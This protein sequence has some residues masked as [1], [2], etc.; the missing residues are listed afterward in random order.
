VFFEVDCASDSSIS[1]YATGRTPVKIALPFA[2]GKVYMGSRANFCEVLKR[3]N[4]S[5]S[6]WQKLA[7]V[8]A[9]FMAGGLLAQTPTAV[10]VLTWRY[11]LT[12]AGDNTQETL[13]TPTNVSSGAFGKLFSL[14]VDDHVYAQPL[15]VPNLTMSDGKVH[16]VLFVATE[17]D[18]IY[19]FD[20]DAKGS[21]IWKV[22]LLTAAYGAGAGATPVPQADV[23]PSEDIG[24]NIGITGTPAINPATD[25]MYVVA[26][27]KE[28]GQ[29][30]SR[31]HAI[32]IITGAE[33]SGS[34]VNI[35]ASVAGTGDGSSGGQVPFLPLWT[36]QRPA[37]DYY[38]GYV[39]IAYSSHGDVSP[40]HGW[41]FAYNASTLQQTAVLCLTPEDRGASV[42]GSGAGMPIDTSIPGGRMFVVT[43]NGDRNTPFKSNSDYGESVLAFNIAN[44][45]LTPTDEWSAFNYETLNDNDWDQGSGGLLMLPDQPGTYLHLIIT[46]GK[47]GRV[48]VLNRDSLG[49]IATGASSNTNAVQD[50]TVSGIPAG[51]GFW[52]T[53]AYW[54]GN[55]Y[56]WAGGDDGGTPNV[57]MQFKLNDGVLSTTPSSQTTFTSAFPGPTFSVS[58]NGTQD[59]I[60]WAVKADQFSSYGP[61]VLYAFDANDLSTILYE[62]DK[63]SSDTAGLA[64]KFSVPVVTNGKVYFAADGEVDV[65]GLTNA[66]HAAAAPVITPSGGT[67]TSSQSVTMSSATSA[68]SIYYTL[69]GSTPTTS[70]TL[71][72]SAITVGT[73]TTINAIAT[74]AGYNPSPVSTA[75]FTFS[76]QAPPVT[77]SPAA[78]TYPSAQTVTISD[79]D[80]N[81]KIY[82]TTDGSTPSASSTAYSG[83]IQVTASETINAIAIDPAM[84]SSNIV[85][86]AYVIQS[87][88]TSIN[89]G[90]GFSSTQGLDLNG[91]AVATN[92][93][94]QLTTGSTWQA[95]SV[96]WNAP[97]SVQAFTTTFQFQE[98]EA[99]ANGFTFT[100]QNM[101]P[102]ALGGDS[103]GLGYPDIQQS[104]AVKF[105]FYNYNNEGSDSTGFYTDGQPPVTPTID[106]SSSGIELNSGDTIQAQITYDGTTLTLNLKDLVTNAT[107]STSTPINIPQTVGGSSAYVGFTG[108]TGGLSAVQ[109]ILTWTYAATSSGS[110]PPASFTLAGSPVSAINVGSSGTSQITA[111]PAG[112]FTGN[113]LLSCAVTNS[114]AGKVNPPTC[115]VTQPQFIM[116]AQAATA[117]LT[118]NTTAGTATTA[119]SSVKR[120]IGYGGGGMLAAVLLICVPRRRK[121]QTLFVLVLLAVVGAVASGCGNGYSMTNTSSKSSSSATTPGNYTITVTGASGSM[122]ETTTVPVTVQ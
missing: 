119:N 109:K 57:G 12:H 27:T 13:L 35:T 54:D 48:T 5:V 99:Q 39:Y 23:A 44:G 74:A 19:A 94:L 16:N 9:L 105:N 31:L 58:S 103:A 95:G 92:S 47:E 87:G 73:D 41:L 121:W 110:N 6:K 7:A 88:G 117:T 15:Y 102:T 36:N 107:Y 69:D 97:I 1:N 34:P 26:N 93:Q 111:T 38:N 65:Y 78:G 116:G 91:T 42:W 106:I 40:Y 108:G 113:I 70:S 83:P 79:S 100:I 29:Y 76:N 50:F 114:P 43:A 33:Q 85:T 53:A 46:A 3:S 115:T 17:N 80:A 8:T 45:Q 63:K 52:G 20:A 10:P 68:A 104:V 96:F 62:S 37:L 86:A 28:N 30:F 101:A 51:E 25:T 21:P 71:Y 14:S 122:T 120:L 55:V 60:V 82:Y 75:T 2:P 61:A 49:G 56:D 32:N 84:A 67:F 11:D 81:A 59:G 66:Q 22:S 18:S 4:K 77:F 89:F 64:N 118:I 24:P 90:S 98:F 72:S 112:G